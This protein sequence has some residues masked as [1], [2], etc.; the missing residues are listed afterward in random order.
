MYFTEPKPSNL[1]DDQL[2]RKDYLQIS[3]FLDLMVMDQ[4]VISHALQKTIVRAINKG[5]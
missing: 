4:K 5:V 1:F 3:A 2:P